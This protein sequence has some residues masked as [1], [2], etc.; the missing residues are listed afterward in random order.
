MGMVRRGECES[1]QKKGLTLGIL[2]DTHNE[3]KLADV[4][5]FALVDRFDFSLPLDETIDK[6]RKIQETLGIACL[7]NVN[8][9]YVSHTAEVAKALGIPAIS[10]EAA[11]FSLDKNL[12]RKRIAERVGP[13][14]CARFHVVKSEEELL[15]CAEELGYPVFLQPGNV[16]ASMWSTLNTT[17]ERL[18]SNY[19]VMVEEVP[20]HYEKLGQ[21]GKMLVVVIAE[22][23]QGSNTSMDC[24]V[25][26]Q[27]SVYTTPIVDVITGF[28][29]GID[30]FHH[31]ARVLPCPMN[32]DQEKALEK[33]GVAGV[34]ALGMQSCAAHVEFI[35][36]R[37]GE[38]A[39]RPGGNRPRILEL[40]Y[41]IDELYAYYQVLHG[42]KPVIRKEFSCS[43]AIV[44]PFPRKKGVLKATR[45]LD[46]IPKLPG[47]LYHEVRGN[48]GQAVG[49]AK[50]GFRA[51]LYIELKSSDPR[52][53]RDSVN[54]ISSWSDIYEVD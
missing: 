34:K 45:H 44:T 20:R 33:L 23:M 36:S 29:I 54:E 15:K 10:P 48:P 37:L 11:R 52:E 12:M 19:R 22:F 18:L 30:D 42:E 28:D 31:F 41:G 47:Y 3:Q 50:N 6:V 27:G 7:F 21:K 4:S 5:S 1:L 16:S 32:L 9:L 13:G 24:L 25:D 46:R 38:I 39:A 2:V 14:S 53:V 35:G 49:L 8:E 40:A 17:T 43:A 26:A 51:P